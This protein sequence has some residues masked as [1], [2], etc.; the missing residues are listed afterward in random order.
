MKKY[1]QPIRFL[2]QVLFMVG[3]L[4]PFLPFADKVGQQIWISILFVG[5]FFCGWICPFGALQD[6]IGWVAKKI[7]LPRFKIPQKY[8]QYV[9][10]C[11]YFLY[12]LSMMNI[13]LGFLNARFFFGHS[14]MKGMWDWVN[15]SVMITFLI[16]TLF[17]DRPFCNYFCMKGASLG[18]WSVLRPFGIA[19]DEKK[20]IHCHLCDKVCPMNICVE[21]TNFLRHP[22]CINCMQCMC[23]CPKNCIKFKLMNINQSLKKK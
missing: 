18:V 8:Q 1:I 21:R 19:R 5:V 3:L 6:W 4:L 17:T 23:K 20:C 10:L 12:G 2:V 22:N 15:G 11:R 7:H 14:A 9:Q 16:L 13:T